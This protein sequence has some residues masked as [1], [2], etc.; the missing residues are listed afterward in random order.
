VNLEQVVHQRWAASDALNS[1][2]AAEH[3]KTGRSFGAALPYAT[4]ARRGSRTALRTSAGDAL[5][6]VTLRVN[7]WHDQ[8]DA[9]R[10]IVHQVKAAFD[11][12]DFA[13]AGGDRVVQMRR[14]DDSASQHSDGTWQFTVD[15]LVQVHLPS[16]V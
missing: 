6:E 4:I 16:G 7:V 12:T 11:R 8:Y 13:L 9:G 3:V 2:L 14:T 1:L 5:D 10:A 15:F